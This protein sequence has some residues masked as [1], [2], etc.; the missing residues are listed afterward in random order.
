MKFLARR[1]VHSIFIL[2]AI[3]FFSFLFLQSAP[4]DYFDAIRMNPD[5]SAQTVNMRRAAYGMNKPFPVRYAIWMRSLAE[6][7]MGV[8]FAYGTPVGPLLWPRARNTLLLTFSA[9]F[10]AWLLAVPLGLWTAAAK[11]G[12]ADRICT[13]ATSGLLVI[14]DLLLFL[15]LLLLAVRTGWFP[16]GGMVSS[17][18]GA[19]APWGKVTD[20][21]R[22]FA[23]PVAGLAIATLPLL[24]R[25]VRAA[26]IEILESPFIRA[27]RGHG[28]PRARLLWRYA[29]PAASNPLISLLGLSIATMLS[30][31]LIV[32]VILSWPGL[33]PLM[34]Q[35]ILARDVNVV[36]GVVMLSSIFLIAGNLLADVLLFAS[37]P[38]IRVE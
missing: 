37:D 4:G 33:G 14:P 10:L 1:L 7:D 25:H 13:F 15:L 17:T 22:H 27:A 6:G 3:S 36:I 9:M 8:S 30:G 26:T 32:E 31:S 29:L 35:A 5:V 2:L 11:G 16:S 20:I 28:V 38:R 12:W 34:I 18:F 23:L 19:L 21:V 24:L